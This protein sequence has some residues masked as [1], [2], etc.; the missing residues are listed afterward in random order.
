MSFKRFY[1]VFWFLICA[2]VSPPGNWVSLVNL[3]RRFLRWLTSPDSPKWGYKMLRL[4]KNSTNFNA[5]SS[6]CVS[7][8]LF[9][10]AATKRVLRLT[11]KPLSS[12][13]ASQVYKEIVYINCGCTR[14]RRPTCNFNNAKWFFGAS[15]KT[16]Y[17]ACFWNSIDFCCGKYLMPCNVAE[18]IMIL[19]V[20][21]LNLFIPTHS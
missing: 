8:F 1:E 2:N 3:L 17:Q 16:I 7:Y 5:V 21:Y 6:V 10:A 4:A 12:D 15:A 20:F 9:L 19:T 18:V 14:W 13:I 11:I